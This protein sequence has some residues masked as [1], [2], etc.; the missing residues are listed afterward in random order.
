VP[1]TDRTFTGQVVAPVLHGLPGP[2]GTETSADRQDGSYVDQELWL[3]VLPAGERLADGLLVLALRAAE[4]DRLLNGRGFTVVG[5]DPSG[6][7]TLWKPFDTSP[8][9]DLAPPWT[10]VS[11][12]PPP[13]AAPASRVVVRYPLGASVA[14]VGLGGRTASALALA[15]QERAARAAEAARRA[16]E[17]AGPWTP[18]PGSPGPAPGTITIANSRSILSP[19]RLYRLDLTLAWAGRLI[20][21]DPSGAAVTAATVDYGAATTS[22]TSVFFR[23]A[24]PPLRPEELAPYLTGYEPSQAEEFRFRNDPLRVHFG[25]DHVTAL[26]KAYGDDL[27][28]TVRA[29]DKPATRT[30]VHDDL[31]SAHVLDWAFEHDPAFLSP[32]DAHRL[33]LA[34]ASTCPLPRPG[35]TGGVQNPQLEPLTWYDLRV[36]AQ[37]AEG[38]TS[39]E[40]PGVTFRTSRWRVPQELVAG[41]GYAVAGFDAG[42]VLVGDLQIGPPATVVASGEPDDAGFAR[43]LDALGLDGWPLADDVRLSRL[44]TLSDGWRFAGL[45]VESPEPVLLPGRLGVTGLTG[46]MLPRGHKDFPLCRRDRLG[47]RLLFLTSTPLPMYVPDPAPPILGW[48]GFGDE[49]GPILLNRLT[50]PLTLAMAPSPGATFVGTLDLPPAPSFA[51][52]P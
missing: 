39:F 28:L 12:A 38:T 21:R 29:V 9:Q 43:A 33:A 22:T 34:N 13:G 52:E 37:I 15:A 16:S 8:V 23:T 26:A 6:H 40:L 35:L 25:Q 24:S 30:G 2:H 50:S 4:T 42:H 44:W 27:R 49:P 31:L 14:V 46:R 48:N 7:E 1:Q 18:A 11:L 47:C 45:V 17:A 10:G 19:G 20:E 32:A 51:E 36:R 41:L 5:V 3:D